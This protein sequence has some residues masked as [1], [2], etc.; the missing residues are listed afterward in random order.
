[1]RLYSWG[2]LG[3]DHRDVQGMEHDRTEFRVVAPNMAA[4]IAMCSDLRPC[5]VLEVHAVTEI[6]PEEAAQWATLHETVG[7]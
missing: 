6:N 3:F 1:M 4:A 5:K 2:I 7:A